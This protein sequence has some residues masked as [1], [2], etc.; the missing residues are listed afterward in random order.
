MM[1]LPAIPGFVHRFRKG[2]ALF[3]VLS[4]FALPVRGE[5]FDIKAHGAIG[6]GKSDDT[7]AIQSAIVQVAQKGGGEVFLP[8][9]RYR[10]SASLK[11]ATGVR[12]RGASKTGTRLVAP[13][14]LGFDLICIDAASDVTVSDLGLE[15]EDASLDGKPTGGA[16][17]INDGSRFVLIENVVVDGFRNGFSI[18]RGEKGSVANVVFRN[19]RTERSRSFGFELNHCREVLLDSCYAFGHWLDGIKLRKQTRDVTIRGGEASDNGTS[20]DK[21]PRWNGNGVDAYA[22][23]DSFVIDGLVVEHNRGS[24]IYIKT[25][26]LQDKGFG[27]VGNVMINQVRCRYNNGSGLDINRSG[28]DLAQAPLVANVSIIGGVFEENSASGI[29]L[30]G[31]NMSIVAPII[32]NNDGDGMSLTSVFDISI[33][34][35]LI[36]ANS[37]KVP[38]RYN[39]ISI[40]SGVLGAHRVTVR[41]GVINGG[42]SDSNTV[43][44][45]NDFENE[46]PSHR[47]AVLISE[48][49]S[50]VTLGGVVFLSWSQSGSPV[51]NKIPFSVK[52]E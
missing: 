49:S 38:G 18:G 3:L 31:R 33:V 19:C 50:E 8:A 39:G 41:G 17:A 22:G 43:S 23:G 34:A 52:G 42:G 29:Y 4:A 47:K 10:V 24:G 36:S 32:R 6:D 5:R 2:L 51:E 30:R 20:R 13:K 46:P 45:G 48:R 35:P 37:R 21:D 40:G 9:G 16:V 12:L 15:E 14:G 44:G 26:E 28:G 27:T 25:G 1:G 11:V 7:A